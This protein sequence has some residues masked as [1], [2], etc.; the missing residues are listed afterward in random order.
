MWMLNFM[1][2]PCCQNLLKIAD[3]FCHLASSFNR[4]ACLH[5]RQSWLMTG[6]LCSEFIG[7]DEWP[8]NSPVFN[9]LDYHVWEATFERYCT[10]H[11][12]PSWRTSM[13]S[14]KFCS[15]WPAAT[16]LDQQS[17]IELPEKT[18]GLCKRWWWTL[19]KHAKMNDLWD[20]GICN[21]CQCFLTMKLTIT[22]CYWLFHAELKTWQRIFYTAINL[23]K[24]KIFFFNFRIVAG[25]LPYKPRN[26]GIIIS[27]GCREIAFCPVGYF[28]LS[29]PVHKCHIY[30]WA[31]V[32]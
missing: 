3:L 17:H 15:W 25:S 26:L 5:T 19:P 12:N 14:R 32:N 31:Y 16:G 28:N 24:I 21:Y 7:K 13:S 11:F 4:T 29:H 10:S 8:P 6:L 23:E 30:S 2:K 1:L 18:S 20:L 27:H 9:P 22:S